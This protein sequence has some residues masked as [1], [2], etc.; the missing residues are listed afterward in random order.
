[1]SAQQSISLTEDLPK[2]FPVIAFDSPANSSHFIN[3]DLS[4]LEDIY[5]VD[6][7]LNTHAFSQMYKID[8]PDLNDSPVRHVE[9][10]AFDA[11]ISIFEAIRKQDVLLHHPYMPY[12]IITDFIRDAVNDPEVLAIKM[13]LP[14]C[15]TAPS[16]RSGAQVPRSPRFRPPEFDNPV[17][18]RQKA[19]L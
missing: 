10:A 4:L 12:S 1:M 13:C 3:R 15:R 6:G 9:P 18:L 19:V 17:A 16:S 2:T 7:P 14:L 5:T 11:T 8:R